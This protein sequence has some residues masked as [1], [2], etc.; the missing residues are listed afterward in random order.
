M[1]NR[2][3]SIDMA[4]VQATA[5]KTEGRRPNPKSAECPREHAPKHHELAC[6][7]IENLGDEIHHAPAYP[8][9]RV[10]A[11]GCHTRNCILNGLRKQ[12]PSLSLHPVR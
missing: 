11:A 8:D 9:D 4:V 2:S 10:N 12:G 1:T 3:S 5:K 6:R 7:E